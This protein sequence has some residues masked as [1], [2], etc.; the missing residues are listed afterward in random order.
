VLVRQISGSGRYSAASPGGPLA[1]EPTVLLG[2]IAVVV[3][4]RAAG[5][6]AHTFDRRSSLFNP[7][8]ASLHVLGGAGRILSLGHS[9]YSDLGRRVFRCTRL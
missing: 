4:R 6:Y 5:D 9:V 7:F 2:A 3:L 1:M 8:A